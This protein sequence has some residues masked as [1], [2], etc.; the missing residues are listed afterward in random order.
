VEKQVEQCSSIP[1]RVRDINSW[2]IFTS[3][4]GKQS[5]GKAG[6]ADSE[7]QNSSQLYDLANS[8]L[9]ECK[10]EASLADL[11]TAIYLFREALDRRP[12]PHPLRSDSIKQLAAALVIRYTQT[13]QPQDL[14][15][16][17]LLHYED[18]S[19]LAESLEGTASVSSQ[20]EAEVRT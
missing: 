18:M 7:D 9:E 17:I 4:W 12:A 8:A 16:A 5:A 11:E 13:D 20:V 1:V 6:M 10:A 19:H 2:L 3:F 14:D 15:E